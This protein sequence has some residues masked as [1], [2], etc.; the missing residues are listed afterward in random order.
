[1]K[2]NKLRFIETACDV[3]QASLTIIENR[4]EFIILLR[5]CYDWRILK[6]TLR[7]LIKILEEV[8]KLRHVENNSRCTY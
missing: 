2:L 4:T 3:L 8:R 5:E 7:E 1:M 6:Q